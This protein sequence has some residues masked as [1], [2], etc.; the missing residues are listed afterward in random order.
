MTSRPNGAR[1][2]LQREIGPALGKTVLVG[3]ALVGAAGLA[4]VIGINIVRQR[5]VSSCRLRFRRPKPAPPRNG[6]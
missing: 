3:V 1:H 2:L 4:A 5:L 6:H